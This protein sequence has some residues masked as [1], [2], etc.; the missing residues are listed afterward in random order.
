[1]LL[2]FLL[3]EW[4]VST[5]GALFVELGDPEDGDEGEPEDGLELPHAATARAVAAMT[6]RREN[7]RL[8]CKVLPL[9]VSLGPAL[10][11]TVMQARS[12]SQQPRTIA[13]S[14]GPFS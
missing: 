1:M 3:N 7:F 14:L 2:K 11:T 12:R 8:T 13:L 9:T 5:G 4:I 10:P 6:E